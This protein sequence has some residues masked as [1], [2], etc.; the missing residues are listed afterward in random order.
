M[1]NRIKTAVKYLFILVPIFALLFFMGLECEDPVDEGVFG[2]NKR[3]YNIRKAYREQI[4]RMKE[5]IKYELPKWHQHLQTERQIAKE[6]RDR[7]YAELKKNRALHRQRLDQEE[8]TREKERAQRRQRER[9][10]N[11]KSSGSSGS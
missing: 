3:L 5:D 4:F 7:E 6:R 2:W 11:K 9:I 8:K 1:K 10:K